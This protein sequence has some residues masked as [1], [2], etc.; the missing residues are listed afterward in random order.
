MSIVISQNPRRPRPSSNVSYCQTRFAHHFS[1]A[2]LWDVQYLGELLIC[3]EMFV[4]PGGKDELTTPVVIQ[5]VSLLVWTYSMGVAS[6]LKLLGQMKIQLWPK[7]WLLCDVEPAWL[8]P[9]YVFVPPRFSWRWYK[10][11]KHVNLLQL[12]SRNQMNFSPNWWPRQQLIDI[13]P[14]T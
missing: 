14:V 9:W 1:V 6:I 11:E 12:S 5:P 4:G 10:T 3:F 13:L 7:R 8:F 2:L